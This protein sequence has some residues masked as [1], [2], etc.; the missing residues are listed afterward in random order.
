MSEPWLIKQMVVICGLIQPR[1]RKRRSHGVTV[2]TEVGRYGKTL[3]C[4]VTSSSSFWRY[5]AKEGCVRVTK[6]FRIPEG[7]VSQ[8]RSDHVVPIRSGEVYSLIILS[9]MDPS[10][11]SHKHLS[12]RL[13]LLLAIYAR[14]N[15]LLIIYSDLPLYKYQ[16]LR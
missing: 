5:G 14:D 12:P 11:L 4:S 7:V 8:S 9:E 10:S 13:K 16:H 15:L 3:W 6:P 1:E 2:M